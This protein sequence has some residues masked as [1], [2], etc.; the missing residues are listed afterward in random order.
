MVTVYRGHVLLAPDLPAPV[1]DRVAA[2][3]AA[4]LLFDPAA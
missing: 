3:A 4:L 1:R 2:V